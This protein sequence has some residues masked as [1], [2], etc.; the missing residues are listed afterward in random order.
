V[1][2]KFPIITSHVLISVRLLNCSSVQNIGRVRGRSGQREFV[3][4]WA[5]ELC[6]A[7]ELCLAVEICLTVELFICS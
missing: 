6:S 3:E 1:L 5:V 4:Y 7:V 2:I